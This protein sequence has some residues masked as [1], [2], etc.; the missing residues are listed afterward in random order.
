MASTSSSSRFSTTAVVSMFETDDFPEGG[1]S[2]ESE[3][4][5]IDLSDPDAGAYSNSE[6]EDTDEIRDNGSE[7]ENSMDELPVVPSEG[8]SASSTEDESPLSKR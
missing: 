8:D 4:D 3:E 6:G 7:G 1:L 5:G 2:S